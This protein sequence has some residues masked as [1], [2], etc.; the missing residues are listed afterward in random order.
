L[1]DARYPDYKVVIPKESEDQPMKTVEFSK[2][3]MLEAIK[4][5][6]K[7]A[8]KQT[9]LVKFSFYNDKMVLYAEDLDLNK[10]AEATAEIVKSNI[11]DCMVIGF[12]WSLLKTLLYLLPEDDL[13]I[14]LFAPN[15]AGIIKSKNTN[16]EFVLLMP[17]LLT[18]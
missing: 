10:S 16:D 1:V 12:D 8:S 17:L 5:V 4:L 11:E 15:K 2:N 18:N 3:I 14:K 9:K 13:Y 7:S 6:E